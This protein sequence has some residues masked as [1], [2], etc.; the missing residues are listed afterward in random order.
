MLKDTG[1]VSKKAVHAYVANMLEALR[2]SEEALFEYVRTEL[3]DLLAE[4]GLILRTYGQDFLLLTLR[5]T[6]SE[7]RKYGI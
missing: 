5:V 7:V 1:R 2:E 4:I 3:P 6:E